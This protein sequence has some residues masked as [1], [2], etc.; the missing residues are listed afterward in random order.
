MPPRWICFPAGV[1]GTT[2]YPYVLFEWDPND[3]LM[4]GNP[5]NFIARSL[6]L[7]NVLQ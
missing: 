4:S 3:N 5:D 1:A 2:S 6:H 7:R